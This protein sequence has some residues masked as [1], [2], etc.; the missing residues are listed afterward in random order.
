[1][2]TPIK[3]FLI[4]ALLIILPNLPLQAAAPDPVLEVLDPRGIWPEIRQTPLSPRPTSLRNKTVYVVNS[5]AID[6]SGF[7]SV[8]E[9]LPAALAKRFPGVNV[10]VVDRNTLYS[11]DDPE[12]WADMKANASA[13][14][15]VGAASSSTTAYAVK[16]SALLEG[17]GIPG[18]VAM[19]D[20]LLSV[21]ETVQAREGVPVRHVDFGYPVE[22]MKPEDQQARIAQVVDALARPLT[23]EE[24]HNGILPRPERPEIIFRGTH[25]EVQ[26]YFHDNGLT[27]GLPIVPP[28]R[29]RVE[30]MLKGTSHD[31]NKV[32]TTSMPPQ[33]LTVT[34]E[35]VAII[36]VMAG[37][38]PEHMPV[39]LASLE[40]FQ[41]MN[42]NA[43]IRSTGSFG[44]MQVVN[45]PIRNELKMNSGT[46]LV[47]PGN[48][49]NSTMGRALRLYVI[50]LGG[51]INGTNLMGVIGSMA[52]WPFLY[53]ENEEESPWEPLSVTHGFKAGEST[54]T[55]YSGGSASAGNYGHVRFGLQQVA[56]DIAEFESG[57]RGVAVIVSP[58]RAEML[59]AEGM[60]KEDVRKFLTE[61]AHKP[62]S[63][64]RKSSFYFETPESRG[65]PPDTEVPVVVPPR[66]IDVIVGGG[67]A[68]PMMQ[69]WH[70]TSP[71]T[72]SIDA[73]R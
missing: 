39:L 38:L 51:G 25:D 9:A 13:F 41:K 34:V 43:V 11:D 66:I 40:A 27:D 6:R 71:V 3:S 63:V 19:Y 45:G 4:S 36:G 56:E 7:Q 16:W 55:L 70:M 53:A 8:I 42:R 50:N 28:T 46:H 5:W 73:W 60:S 62:L 29:E 31:R 20:T 49:A 58:K 68:S 69:A 17:M 24:R 2:T 67:D 12:L 47:S 23:A 14:I 1:M 65:L 32:L 44:F 61:N 26:A 15:Y 37:A 18:V 33:E 21:A 48:R 30:A 64:L 52:I 57:G 22:L 54:L 72:V 59:A 35:K 10:K